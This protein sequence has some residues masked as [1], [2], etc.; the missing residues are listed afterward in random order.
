MR[1]LL[2]PLLL[3]VL[4]AAGAAAQE[5]G[6]FS[7]VALQLV[8]EDRQRNGLPPLEPGDALDAAAA[9]PAEDMLRRDYYAHLSPE[10]EG[11]Q[12]RYLS[13]G[14]SQWEFVAEN[15]A[16]CVGCRLT[17]ER[18][19]AF[20]Q[21]WMESPEHRHNI[22]AR[23]LDRFGFGIAA[24][25]GAVY[26]VQTFAG[27]GV[28]RGLGEGETA[29]PVGAT[30]AARLMLDQINVARQEAGVPALEL[31][32]DLVSAA[33]HL[34]PDADDPAFSA[35]LEGGLYEALPEAGRARWARLSTA[36]GAC[37]GCGREP[38][39]ADVLF[40]AEDWL[41]DPRL[42]DSLV[43]QNFTHLGFGIAASGAGKKVAVAVIGEQ[44]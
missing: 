10:G 30:E 11:V 12:D 19:R 4:C 14:G 39:G 22:L 35:H 18:V 3:W 27:P 17:S 36:S 2:L 25:D 21:G 16:R 23:G 37:G 7:A 34:L 42:R 41:G 31:S 32:D 15:I 38:T 24:G 29:E 1:R 9:A 28:P 8:N 40:F 5:A 33:D 43:A 26:A 13:A 6:E 20:Q 44:R